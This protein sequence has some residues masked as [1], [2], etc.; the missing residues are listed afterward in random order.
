LNIF[1]RFKK[2]SEKLSESEKNMISDLDNLEQ[3]SAKPLPSGQNEGQSRG[4]FTPDAPPA[5]S[6]ALD[7]WGTFEQGNNLNVNGQSPSGGLI[8]PFG[9]FEQ[10][11][12]L[13]VSGQNPSG[14][15][16]DPFKTFEQGNNLNVS[17][18]SPSGGLIDPFKTFEQGNNL[19]ASGQNP[20]PAPN[21]P[22]VSLP[23][24]PTIKTKL[25]QVAAAT[26]AAAAVAGTGLMATAGQAGKV[27]AKPFKGNRPLQKRPLFWV[28]LLAG[29]GIGS[30]AL[31]WLIVDQSVGKYSMKS[32][33]HFAR[34]GTMTV[35]AMDGTNLLQLGS[36][37]S[38]NLK[39]WQF[40]D[41][42]K[43]AFI[44][45]EDRRFYEHDGVDYKGVVR[46][47]SSNISSRGLTEGA[48][49]ITQQVA[50]MVYL[51][52]D[53]NFLRKIKEIR[54]AQKI[55]KE[56]GKDQILERYLNLVYLGEGTYG[57]ADAAWV[58]FGKTVNQLTLPQMATLAALPPSPN[59]YSPFVNP[60]FSKDRRNLVLSRMKEAGFITT[61]EMT[62]AQA[63][64]MILQRKD[65]KQRFQQARY[66]TKYIEQELETG[67]YLKKE[68]LKVGGLIVET[69]LN[70]QW[71][72]TAEEV[73]K[74]TVR[75][76]GRAFNQGA[77]LSIDPR[78]GAIR[79]MVG[80]K[81]FSEKNQFNRVTQARRQPGS[82]FKPILYTTAIAGG[83]SP[84]K[85]YLDAPFIIDGK[86]KPKNASKGF[87]GQISMRGA[88]TN[89]INI[90]AIKILIDTGF[91]PVMDLAQKMGIE[92]ELQ[93]YYSLALGSLEVTLLELT[94]AYGALATQ[95]IHQKVHSINRILDREGNVLYENKLKPQ[96]IL[97]PNNTAIITSMM[98]NVVN[99]GTGQAA[100]LSRPVA[101]K[102]G[103]TDKE[104]DLWFMGFI[105]QVVTG[106]WLGND[107]NSPTG[108]AS[109]TAARAWG[110]FMS[111]VV[112]D[113]PVQQF[114]VP[115]LDKQKAEIKLDRVRPNSQRTLA[116][117]KDFDKED[118]SNSEDRPRRRARSESSNEEE[119]PRRRRVRSESSSEEEQ[120]RRRRVRSESSNEEEQPRRRRVRSESSSE[121]EQPRRRRSESSGEEQPRRRRSESSGE[122][123]PRVKVQT[124]SAGGSSAPAEPS[125]D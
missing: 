29:L 119:Q 6:G 61:A 52:Q 62:E 65:H 53:K 20:S 72:T 42:L 81:E 79:A 3:M 110:R 116:M 68:D 106:V 10:G 90:V 94:N 38:E 117:P 113:M 11:N 41:K 13:N 104:K 112:K 28:S 4:A 100:Q 5:P 60:K 97:Q 46:A 115:D 17:G 105:P 67:K 82:T 15:S 50:R 18:Q 89:S 118:S 96:R 123:R 45:I 19:N 93:P 66:F 23:P 95:G 25:A 70:P 111:Q 73:I 55:E 54:L 99:E 77:M 36:D 40:P 122:E 43:K 21:R 33:L 76:N 30:L 101:G 75:N 1:D 32:P 8:D 44:A 108:N 69:T 125:L 2:I 63:A 49:S 91:Q 16:I 48:S 120:P 88:L 80:G 47:I 83:I 59:K 27:A 37:T 57:V 31:L 24:V 26:S 71:Q 56:L 34:P 51:D 124:R 98:R 64:P 14:G 103:T 109:S 86:Y 39:L 84:N 74:S 102:T 78:S 12:N 87:K 58:Y 107:D 7:P 92:S 114:P 85:T 35:K 9:T 22:Q 121:E